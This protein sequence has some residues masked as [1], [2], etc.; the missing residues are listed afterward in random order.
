MT[1]PVDAGSERGKAVP[2]RQ[3]EVQDDDSAVRVRK[4]NRAV[5]DAASAGYLASLALE[6]VKHGVTEVGLV[7][8]DEHAQGGR[9]DDCGSCYYLGKTPGYAGD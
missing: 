5:G 6:I 2:I 4:P 1:P 3:T 8:D 9:V 7:L